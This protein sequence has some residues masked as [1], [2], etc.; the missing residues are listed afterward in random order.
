[1]LQLADII[2]EYATVKS[3]LRGS[4]RLDIILA[5]GSMEFIAK[6]L[7]WLGKMG[8]PPILMFVEGVGQRQALPAG[9]DLFWQKLSHKRVGGV[10]T[11]VGLFGFIRLKD[12]VMEAKF[13]REI[14]HIVNFGARPKP[15]VNS[16]PAFKHYKLGD[17]L[18][19][20]DLGMPVVFTTHRCGSGFGHKTRQ[21]AQ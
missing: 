17:R 20:K 7:P 10:T 12:W 1:M 3:L 18:R 15:T 16:D 9:E 2:R 8:D 14:G 19:Q 21:R 4:V 11:Q 5:S 13:G 6:L